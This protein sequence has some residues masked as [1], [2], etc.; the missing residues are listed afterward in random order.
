MLDLKFVREHL[1]AVEQAL[2]NRGQEISLEEFRRREAERRQSLTRLEEWRHTR[3]TLSKEVGALMKAGRQPEAQAL[4]ERAVA[5]NN[6]IKSLETQAEARDAWVREFLLNLPNMPHE[7]VPVGATSDDNPVVKTW[8]EAPRFDFPPRAHWDIGEKLGILDF[9]RAAKITGAR[10]ALLK[11]A[12][13]LMERALI[14]FMLDLHTKKH[15]YLEVLPPFMTN[16]DSMRGT[17]QLP[18]FKEDLFKL[19]GLNYFLV[20]TAEVPVTNIHRDEILPA[21]DLPLYYTAYTPCFRSEAGS[22][23]KDVRG[24]IRQHQ[25]NKVELVKFTLPEHSYDEL[26]RLLLDAEE[27]LQ[28]LGLHYRVVVLCTGDMGFA[29]AKTYDIEVWLPGQE[30]Y[31]EISSCSNFADYQARR[32][33]IRFRRPGAKGTELVHTL[34]GS[35]LAVGRTLVAILENYQQADG[36]VVIPEKLRPYM[37][38]MEKIG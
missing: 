2:K 31:R 36:R 7:S 4:K 12:G 30:L 23:G 29:A 3:N 26:E 25:F 34:N 10:F 1:E 28:E 33:G 18:K 32:A 17:G 21:E 27:V 22:Y 35:G 15:G 14:N 19:E 5:V 6:D 13:A 24:L 37:G 16:E 20:P 38:G 8:G 9:E 11:G